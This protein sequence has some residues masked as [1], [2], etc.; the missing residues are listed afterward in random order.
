MRNGLDSP[1]FFGVSGFVNKS[2]KRG[3]VNVGELLERTLPPMGYEL[4]DWDM[5][6]RSGLL[7]VFIDKP[8][9]IDVEDCADVSNHLSR[10]FTVENVEYDR[11]EVSSPGLDRPLKNAADFERYAGEEARLTLRE[12][13]DNARRM[14]VVLRGVSGESVLVE[15]ESVPMSIPLHNIEKARLVPRIEWRQTK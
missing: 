10:L 14:K 8:G 13:I 11:L 15:R 4:V 9:G 12:A 7:R 1:F 3:N 6:P 5:S 2:G